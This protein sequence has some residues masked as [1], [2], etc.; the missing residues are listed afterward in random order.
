MTASPASARLDGLHA[1]HRRPCAGSLPGELLLH[2]ADAVVLHSKDLCIG[3]GYC[4]YACPF[5]APQ[6]PKVATLARAARWTSAPTAPADLRR[7]ARKPS[8]TST[9][10][11]RLAEG[12]AALCAEMCSTKSLLAGDGEIHRADLQGA[13]GQAWVRFRRLGLEDGIQGSHRDLTVVMA[14]GDGAGRLLHRPQQKLTGT[15][16]QGGRDMGRLLAKWLA[17]ARFSR[18]RG[19]HVHRRGGGAGCAQQP[20][21]VNP[22]A[23]S[24]K[25]TSSLPR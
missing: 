18:P 15:Q 3:C 5:G 7:T 22:T 16:G 9:A 13:R 11:N 4:F 12:K 25:K 21:S 20:S 2:H 14:G 24:V 19:A 1:L 6:Y 23:S 10:S 8:T 17:Q